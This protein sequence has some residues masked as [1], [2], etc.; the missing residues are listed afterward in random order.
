MLPKIVLVA[1][2]IV[3]SA[4]PVSAENGVSDASN[5]EILPHALE[6]AELLVFPEESDLEDYLFESNRERLLFGR[7]ST[8]MCDPST[9]ECGQAVDR[10]AKRYARLMASDFRKMA[11][12]DA[13]RRL[14][15]SMSAEALDATIK[16]LNSKEGREFRKS[17]INISSLKPKDASADRSKMILVATIVHMKQMRADFVSE[18]HDLPTIQPQPSRLPDMKLKPDSDGADRD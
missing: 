3:L 10:V 13:A 18:T 17:F 5:V 15:S 12:V 8:A 14:S 1:L 2:A 4:P 11:Q 9:V 16:F 6:I 7:F